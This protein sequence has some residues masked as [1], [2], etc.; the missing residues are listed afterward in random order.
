M[1]AVEE[2]R[3][4]AE[5][6]AVSLLCCRVSGDRCCCCWEV[7]LL[8]LLLKDEDG[9]IAP[10]V[11]ADRRGRRAGVGGRSIRMLEPPGEQE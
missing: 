9:D 2:Q 7:L 1:L 5:L 11:L 8:W 3:E 4:D 10:S 6:L